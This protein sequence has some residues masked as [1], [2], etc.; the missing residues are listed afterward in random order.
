[1]ETKEKPEL[2]RNEYIKR[3]IERTEARI[4][5]IVVEELN[6]QATKKI[7]VDLMKDEGT[8]WG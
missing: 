4:R 3:K 1:M 7:I 8:Y 5:E 6:K 2:K